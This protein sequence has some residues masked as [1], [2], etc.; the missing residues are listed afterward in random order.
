ML[1]LCSLLDIAD[2]TAILQHPFVCSYFRFLNFCT[3]FGFILFLLQILF[4][5]F[6]LTIFLLL[7]LHLSSVLVYMWMDE[8]AV[9]WAPPLSQCHL[10]GRYWKREREN[11]EWINRGIFLFFFFPFLSKSEGCNFDSIVA[12]Q[13]KKLIAVVNSRRRSLASTSEGGGCQDTA[14]CQILKHDS[15]LNSRNS[16]LYSNKKTDAP[17]SFET[18]R[19]FVS[20]T[21]TPSWDK[22][23]W[24]L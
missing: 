24:W 12:S 22:T 7:L 8:A 21:S 18:N 15:S 19:N 13:S 14:W 3:I 1:H 11:K 16:K 9:Y 5:F 4:F 20:F 2:T 10:E 6:L 17:G 23:G